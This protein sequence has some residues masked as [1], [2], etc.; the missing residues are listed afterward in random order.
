[1]EEAPRRPAAAHALRLPLLLLVGLLLGLP[2]RSAAQG[3]P[4][5]AS[6]A[7]AGRTPAV[8]V[9]APRLQA[10]I[11]AQRALREV[12]ADAVD[13]SS[14]GG[15]GLPLLLVIA[16]AYGL[17]HALGPGHRKTALAAYF[18]ARPAPLGQGVAAGISVALLH[19]AAALIAIYGLYYLFKGTVSAAFS[20]V[21]SI[22]EPASYAT[23]AL[24][25]LLLLLLA[26]R[27][28]LR[29][30]KNASHHSEARG[31]DRKT[32]IAIIVGAGVVPCPGT[33]LLL[34][35]CLSQNLPWIGVLTALVMA[36]G[37]AVITVTVSLAAILGERGLFAAVPR[38]SRLGGMLH[39]G[40]EIGGAALLAAFGLFM[41]SP[42]L[43]GLL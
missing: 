19:A 20:S 1:M 22:L 35:L 31:G 2:M 40:L 14:S 43:A 13:R 38:S 29:A 36:A 25:G 41:L 37:M 28:R 17:L 11:D 8:T 3:N 18:V 9:Q 30:Q 23:I 12:L 27:E 10:L 15:A 21:N 34:I 39:H 26:V 7:P 16:F 24:L 33:A 42:Y 32:L 4:F 6:P 5:F